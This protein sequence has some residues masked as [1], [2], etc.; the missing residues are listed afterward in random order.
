MCAI[1]LFHTLLQTNDIDFYHILRYTVSTPAN[2]KIHRRRGFK[3][4]TP[5]NPAL[6]VRPLSVSE[7]TYRI[8]LEPFAEDELYTLMNTE[9]RAKLGI[10]PDNVVWDGKYIQSS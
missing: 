1:S 6:P 8:N 10:I 9:I 4:P 5:W 3:R 2:K 7:D